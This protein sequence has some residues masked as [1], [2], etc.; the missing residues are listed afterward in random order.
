[1]YSSD[2]LRSGFSFELKTPQ[3]NKT[4][5]KKKKKKI[6][7][8]TCQHPY[9]TAASP[10]Y[11]LLP[12]FPKRERWRWHVSK[13]LKAGNLDWRINGQFARIK[14]ITPMLYPT[15]MEG[16]WNCLTQPGSDP[17]WV[18]QNGTPSFSM[19]RSQCCYGNGNLRNK[20]GA[21]SPEHQ[22]LRTSSTV[23]RPGTTE[24]E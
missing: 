23:K 7:P 10:P 3:Q 14:R 16:P 24:L 17:A 11:S 9:L 12:L 22:S 1:M 4:R 15:M 6:R 21:H 19:H 13:L 8:V 5:P 2:S 18:V 20:D